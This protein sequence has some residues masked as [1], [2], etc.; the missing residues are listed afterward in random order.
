M[1]LDQRSNDLEKG[2]WT[3]YLFLREFYGA[4]VEKWRFCCDVEIFL[5][6]L[7]EYSENRWEI[8]ENIKNLQKFQGTTKWFLT[9]FFNL[10]LKRPLKLQ[11]TEN[12][13]KIL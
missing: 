9:D 10:N 8:F 11:K 3:W 2:A 1:T 7:E 6:F 4:E 13:Q 5:M 12:S